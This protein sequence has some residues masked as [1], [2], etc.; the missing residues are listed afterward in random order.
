[1][2]ESLYKENTKH[3]NMSISKNLKNLFHYDFTNKNILESGMGVVWSN[4]QLESFEFL[5]TSKC[6]FIE[7]D[8]RLKLNN[9][10]IVKC[11]LSNF[12][13]TK[14]FIIS[15]HGGNSSFN[16]HP[17]HLKTLEKINSNFF[18]TPVECITYKHFIENIVKEKINVLILDI[19]GHEK[20]VLETF[21]ELKDTQ[22]P[23]IL[24]IE[25]GYEW[26][27]LK[28]LIQDLGYILQC[29][30]H[31]NCYFTH[32]HFNIDVNESFKQQ[33]L[34]TYQSFTYEGVKIY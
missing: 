20:E 10:N 4:D 19:E 1:M 7:P 12:N 31:N 30:I 26:E 16:Y 8:P 25:C 15:S 2:L 13:G 6:W 18:T 17:E 11:A 21:K 32:K 28:Q 24:V 5:N 9:S 23:E 34:S 27:M 29:Y 33:M 22:L 3:I 14:E